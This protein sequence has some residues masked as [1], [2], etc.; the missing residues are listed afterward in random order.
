MPSPILTKKA[1]WTSSL[2]KDADRLTG[3]FAVTFEKFMY[4][5][6]PRYRTTSI[7]GEVWKVPGRNRASLVC[8]PD[9][10]PSGV[11]ALSNPTFS[12]GGHLI[13]VSLTGTDHPEN[14]APVSKFTNDLQQAM[15]RKIKEK[16]ASPRHLTVSVEYYPED[17]RVPRTFRYYLRSLVRDKQTGNYP[18]LIDEIISQPVGTVTPVGTDPALKNALQWA[19]RAINFTGW[20]V[21]DVTST[22]VGRRDLTFL[23]GV[24]LPLPDRRPYAALDY[25]MTSRINN[26]FCGEDTIRQYVNSI[27]TGWPFADVTKDLVRRANPILHGDYLVSDAFGIRHTTLARA[28]KSGVHKGMI[29]VILESFSSLI[30]GGGNNAPQVDH[31]VPQAMFGANCLSNAQLTSA[32][33][34]AHKQDTISILKFKDPKWVPEMLEKMKND[35]Q[36]RD[37]I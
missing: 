24:H 4:D 20:K 9:I 32:H 14:I 17:P 3:N 23:R 33:Y 2:E 16:S 5:G 1:V 34:N 19:E 30:N 29:G 15:E 37:W 25:L 28:D 21:E 6:E 8:L 11:Q 13:A 12:I 10:L 36:T 22:Q 26:D 7:S 35:P 18:V 31:I 27:N